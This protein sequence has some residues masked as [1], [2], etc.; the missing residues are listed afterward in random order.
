MKNKLSIYL[1]KDQVTD[2][3]SIFKNQ[4]ELLKE[5]NPYK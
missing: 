3:N 2:I 1:I 5:Y 4:I